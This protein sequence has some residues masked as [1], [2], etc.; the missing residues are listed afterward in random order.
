MP[1]I[2]L[3]MTMAGSSPGQTQQ[4]LLPAGLTLNLGAKMGSVGPPGQPLLFSQGRGGQIEMQVGAFV[5]SSRQL[6]LNSS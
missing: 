4:V 2:P 1:Q 5:C 6:V 3:T